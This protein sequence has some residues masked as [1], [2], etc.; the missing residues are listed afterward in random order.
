M[1]H[2]EARELLVEAF[3]ASRNASE[4]AKIFRVSTSTLYRLFDRYR[5]ITHSIRN[6]RAER[7]YDRR[8]SPTTTSQRQL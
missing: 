1:L 6:S 2:N 3:E 7:H 4:V 5:F 8:N